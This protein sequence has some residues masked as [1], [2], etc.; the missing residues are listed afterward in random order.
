MNK[1]KADFSYA[2]YSRTYDIIPGE[3]KTGTYF[4]FNSKG[5]SPG[6]VVLVDLSQDG[7]EI[8]EFFGVEYG[9]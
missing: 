6:F 3:S 2:V 5:Q 7:T 9:Q 8:F 4:K 1:A